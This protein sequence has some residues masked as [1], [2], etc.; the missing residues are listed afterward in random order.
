MEPGHGDEIVQLPLLPDGDVFQKVQLFWWLGKPLSDFLLKDEALL[1]V[2][3]VLSMIGLSL[4][5]V[6]LCLGSSLMWH[7]QT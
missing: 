4:L 5:F 6:I 2:S 1:V 3:D 7:L